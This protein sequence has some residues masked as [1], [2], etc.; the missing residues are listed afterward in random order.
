[1]ELSGRSDGGEE[2]MSMDAGEAAELIGTIA[3]SLRKDPTQFYYDVKLTQIGT[4]IT[5]QGP[6]TGLSVTVTGG[7]TGTTIGYVSSVQGGDV[8]VEAIRRDFD[9]K[10]EEEVKHITGI[11]DEIASGLKSSSSDR[12]RLKTLLGQLKKT[13]LV[14]ALQAVV[15]TLVSSSFS[16]R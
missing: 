8:K 12:G 4:S 14:P 7:G 13:V 1:M 9:A 6:G 15:A 5:Q 10:I 16:A 2:V 3:E 11:L